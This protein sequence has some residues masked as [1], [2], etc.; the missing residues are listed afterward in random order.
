MQINRK[1]LVRFSYLGVDGVVEAPPHIEA[2]DEG[3]AWHS[4]SVQIHS[5]QT[6]VSLVADPFLI[7]VYVTCTGSIQKCV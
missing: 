3:A 6:A 5:K 4:I 1:C 7:V 2:L